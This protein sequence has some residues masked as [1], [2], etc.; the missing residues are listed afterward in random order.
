MNDTSSGLPT[1]SGVDSMAPLPIQ[2]FGALPSVNPMYAT[3]SPYTA[4][5]SGA[6]GYNAATIDPNQSQSYMN[7]AYAQNAQAL[8]PQ[9]AQ[10]QQQ[11]QDSS[12]ARGISSSGAAGYLQGNLLGGQASALAQADSPL[13][14]QGYGYN[15]QDLTSNQAAQ[16]AAGQFNAGNQQQTNFAN[17]NALNTAGQFNSAQGTQNSQFNAS[18][19]NTAAQEN[20]NFYGNALGS[21]AN[22]YNNY[23]GTLESQGYNT[24]NEAY[25]AYLSSYLPA[26]AVGNSIGNAAT[27][28]N[29]TYNNVYG[30][31]QQGSNAALGAA[32][33]AF[34]GFSSA[35]PSAGGGYT[36]NTEFTDAP[37]IL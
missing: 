6:A 30:G 19:G 21:N 28:Y 1:S 2:D 29:Q 34:G 12:A 27:G 35:A 31:A 22:T 23:L 24:G 37:Y 33:T 18:V 14:Q 9:F 8:A 7:A 32:G 13:T 25:G 15:Q 36:G 20:A 4:A 26:G 16:N 11:L 3:A 10:Q 17:Q 5:Q